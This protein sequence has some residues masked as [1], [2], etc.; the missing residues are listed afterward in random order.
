MSASRRR[1]KLGRLEP[2]HSASSRPF[3]IKAKSSSSSRLKPLG[4]ESNSLRP[5][6]SLLVKA[7]SGFEPALLLDDDFALILMDVKMPEMDGRTAEADPTRK[8][9]LTPRSSA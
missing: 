6:T 4:V 8:R 2:V 1:I 7:S 5:W 9:S 3:R